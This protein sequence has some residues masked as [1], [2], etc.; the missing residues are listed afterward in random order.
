MSHPPVYHV[1]SLC[2]SFV[3]DVLGEEVESSFSGVVF[4]KPGSP[5]QQWHIDSP[6]EAAGHR[7]PHAVNV[8][9]AL[10]EIPLGDT[11][12]CDHS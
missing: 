1:A 9:L 2:C 11:S 5:A 7:P 10:D 12:E 3:K 4:S 6:R 8:L